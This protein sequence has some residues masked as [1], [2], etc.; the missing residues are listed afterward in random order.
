[1]LIAIN[2][3]KVRQSRAASRLLLYNLGDVVS[4]ASGTL[5][6][7]RDAGHEGRGG[8]R[9]RQW[10]RRR[11]AAVRGAPPP[12]FHAPQSCRPARAPLPPRPPDRTARRSRSRYTLTI[13][14]EWVEARGIPS[15]GDHLVMIVIAPERSLCR[16]R[17]RCYAT[18]PRLLGLLHPS[19]LYSS[20]IINFLSFTFLTE[21]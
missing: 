17:V 1:M 3:P 20:T 21:K 7:R 9:A 4:V 15:S 6:C 19:T 16:T 18:S 2:E 5:R 8:G 14:N 11:R 13:M 10:R 12:S